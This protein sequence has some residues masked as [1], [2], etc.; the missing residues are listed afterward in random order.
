M[1]RDE[2]IPGITAQ[3]I[4]ESDDDML[5][6]TGSMMGPEGSPY[7]G[8][9]FEI[10]I[11]IPCEFPFKPPLFRFTTK[12]YHPNISPQAYH[13]I[14]CPWGGEINAD[15]ENVWRP[16]L[17]IEKI[18]L[19]IQSLLTD[20]NPDQPSNPPAGN[21]LRRNS[22]EYNRMVQE[23]VMLY[24]TPFC[25]LRPIYLVFHAAAACPIFGPRSVRA[26]YLQ[27]PA[28]LGLTLSQRLL[29]CPLLQQSLLC[30]VKQRL[31]LMC[32]SCPLSTLACRLVAASNRSE[33]VTHVHW[34]VISSI[35]RRC[36]GG[37]ALRNYPWPHRS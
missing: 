28:Q 10:D 21:M 2:K 13:P 4:G 26:H 11:V 3:P 22:D 36:F 24:A 8:G 18:L 27:P 6:W 23:W 33:V 31:Q 16:N 15:L 5:H 29:D 9:I 1:L 7:Q 17:A 35:M 34:Q 19:S 32:F 25:E 37:F 12:L 20:P 30:R 14:L